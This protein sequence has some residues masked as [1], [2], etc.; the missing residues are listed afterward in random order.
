MAFRLPR[1]PEA[2]EIVTDKRRPTFKL[3]RWWQSVVTKLET[4]EGTQDALLAQI[5]AAQAAADAA[6]ASADTAIADAAAAQAAADAALAA[7]DAISGS[8]TV[9][10]DTALDGSVSN[11]FVDASGGVRTI[12]LPAAVVGLASINITKIDATANAVNVIPQGG[13]T[14]NGGAGPV[15]STTQNEIKTFVSDGVDQ[16][17]G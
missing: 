3:Q 16:W 1:L 9:S 17:F 14:L 6:Q 8:V 15:S 13:D 5:V 7:V 10:V 4:Q 2:D 12:T 11:I